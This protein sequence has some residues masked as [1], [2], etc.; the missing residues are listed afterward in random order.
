[1]R[2]IL[3][4]HSSD[5]HLRPDGAGDGLAPLRLVLG[6]TRRLGADL[7]L[8]AGDVFD[9]NR[10]PSSLIEEA[11]GLF[12]A[13]PAPVVLLP[14]NHDCIV[15]GGV[16]EHPALARV[17]GLHIIGVNNDGAVTFPHLELEAWGRPH[18]GYRDMRPLARGRPRSTRWSVAMAHGHWVTRPEDS[19]RSWLITDEEIASTGADYVALGHWELAQPAGD[20]RVPAH[21]SGSPQRAGTV[22]VVRL[23]AGGG[24]EVQRAPLSA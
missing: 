16:Y 18:Q 17:S 21:Y 20:G 22:N 9:A 15:P 13:S 19:L 11:A 1:M 23:V 2:D 14:G 12:A 7:L 10:L 3:L 8:L 6:V 4:V 24:V 5:L